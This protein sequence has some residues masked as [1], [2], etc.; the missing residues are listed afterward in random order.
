VV[1]DLLKAYKLFEVGKVNFVKEEHQL[2]LQIVLF[3]LEK[4]KL[5]IE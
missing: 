2:L 5:Q 1:R 3:L 4:E